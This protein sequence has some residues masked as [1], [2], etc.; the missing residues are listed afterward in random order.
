MI[1][2]FYTGHFH[3]WFFQPSIVLTKERHSKWGRVPDSASSQNYSEENKQADTALSL[4]FQRFLWKT[5][6]YCG[7]YPISLS[8]ALLHYSQLLWANLNCEIIKWFHIFQS[9]RVTVNS[10]K[11]LRTKVWGRDPFQFPKI[12]KSWKK[13]HKASRV[14]LKHP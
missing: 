8:E 13:I 11:V 9:L 5:Y 1:T 4:M 3:M 12:S 10:I 14:K 2:P 6:C 7:P